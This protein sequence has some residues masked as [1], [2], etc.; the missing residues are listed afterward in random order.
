ML[1]QPSS[2]KHPTQMKPRSNPINKLFGKKKAAIL[3]T[4]VVVFVVVITWYT[5]YICFRIVF[6]VMILKK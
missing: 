3:I 6:V 1:Y 4:I 2:T 5:M